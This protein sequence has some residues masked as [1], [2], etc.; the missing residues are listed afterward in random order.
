[1]LL[2]TSL[3]VLYELKL[4]GFI[5]KGICFVVYRVCMKG[6][7][8]L[9]IKSF[10]FSLLQNSLLLKS[11]YKYTSLFASMTNLENSDDYC[12]FKE[13]ENMACHILSTSN[14]KAKYSMVFLA[15]FLVSPVIKLI[16]IQFIFIYKYKN[17]LQ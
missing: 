14:E 17:Q 11:I 9:S 6:L 16:S 10:S 15:F 2:Y 4:D 7:Y 3:L 5:H 8:L 13:L 1:M 12:I